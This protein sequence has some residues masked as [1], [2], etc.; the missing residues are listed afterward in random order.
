MRKFLLL[1]SAL[2]LN[3]QSAFAFNV[4]TFIDE[5]VAPITNAIADLVFT[6][7]K[8]GSVDMPLI[9]LWILIAGFFFTFYTANA[10]V[11]T[12]DTTI[13]ITT[14]SQPVPLFFSIYASRS[15]GCRFIALS[16]RLL[17]SFI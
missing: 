7:I 15:S 6:S 9:M 1:M 5:K 14:P 10:P 13:K 11:I 2:L 8:I 16:V 4:D 3:L 12:T 17:I